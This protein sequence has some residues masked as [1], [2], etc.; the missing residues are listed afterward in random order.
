MVISVAHWSSQLKGKVPEEL[1]LNP[2]QFVNVR[3]LV[4]RSNNGTVIKQWK[5]QRFILVDN[6][7]GVPKVESCT[8]DEPQSSNCS[9]IDTVEVVM[10][11]KVA[12]KQNSKILN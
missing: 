1:T 3:V 9:F 8:L 7:T 12:V 4:R 6:R 11:G 5:R 2:F 10:K